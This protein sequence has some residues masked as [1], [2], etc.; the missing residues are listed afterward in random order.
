MH[1]GYRRLQKEEFMKHEID[2]KSLR[3][4]GLLAGI[5]LLPL[6]AAAQQAQPAAPAADAIRWE[7]SYAPISS[8][9]WTGRRLADGQPDIHGFWSNTISNHSN[10]TDPNAGSPGQRLTSPLPPRAERAPSRVTDP[11]DGQFPFQPWA[12]EKVKEFQK[13]F[14]NPIKPEYIEPLARCAPA[15]IPKS[16]YWHGYEIRQYPG[17][18]V[19]LF[20][21]GTRII[22]LDGKPP[23]PDNI[24]LWNADSRGHWEGNTLVVEVNNNNAKALFGRTGEF[25]SENAKITERYIFDNS[26]KRYN[27]VATF[28]DP[29]VLTR[30]VTLTVPAKRWDES[31]PTTGWHFKAVR[32]TH[33]G[34][35]IKL[36]HYERVCAE[37]NGGFGVVAEGAKR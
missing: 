1:N 14:P 25:V 16:L 6:L 12:E 11:A 22:H 35:D 29:T 13:Y 10:I 37:N 33:D 20:D 23:L 17:Y 31:N 3:R 19:F 34:K 36:D 4:T 18:I 21:S 27:Y 28:T 26:N 9:K 32:A 2:L 7:K 24:K 15:G 8:G 30:P 5:A